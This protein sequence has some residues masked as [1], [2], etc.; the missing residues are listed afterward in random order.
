MEQLTRIN[1]RMAELGLC[2]R[3]EADVLIVAGAVRVN[4]KK[5][6]LGQAVSTGDKITITNSGETKKVYFAYYKG[7][8]IITHSPDTGETD[9]ATRLQQDYQITG[10]YPIGRLDKD[11]EGLLLLTNDGRLTAPLL[12][13]DNNIPKT[14]EVTVDKPVVG[15]FLQKLEHGVR[16]ESYM[17]KPAKAVKNSSHRFTLTLTEGKKH[18]IRRMCAALGYQVQ[19]LKRTQIANIA[20]GPLKPNQYRKLTTTEL[21]DLSSLLKVQL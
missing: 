19:T 6:V 3:R 15:A 5:A 10:V 9:I 12:N 14:Y 7:R 1:K 16:I 13:P 11:S 18:Q 20:L 2:S 8:G 4:G 17:T 21:E